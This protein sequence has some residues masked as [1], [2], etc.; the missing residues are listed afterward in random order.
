[1]PCLIF[2]DVRIDNPHTDL[3]LGHKLRPGLN[4]IIPEKA[5]NPRDVVPWAFGDER[6]ANSCDRLEVP[7]DKRIG[8]RWGIQHP[9][10]AQVRLD[11]IDVHFISLY[12]K[13]RKKRI[14]NRMQRDPPV[15]VQ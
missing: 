4:K 10:E 8:G 11:I 12:E 6:V 9:A 2:V 7:P 1:M 14:R 15:S 13:R 3:N 5:C